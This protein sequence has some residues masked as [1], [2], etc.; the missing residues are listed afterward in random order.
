MAPTTSGKNLRKIGESLGRFADSRA[1]A[2][3]PRDR[4]V[5]QA[6]AGTVKVVAGASYGTI[7]A[8][9]HASEQQ[10]RAVISA[11]ELLECLKSLKTKSEYSFEDL[12]KGWEIGCS[13]GGTDFLRL[14]KKLPKFL[15]P[16]GPAEHSQGYIDIPGDTLELMGNMLTATGDDIYGSPIN[17][18]G[19]IY[20]GDKTVQ[21]NSTN[22]I[23]FSSVIL[24]GNYD[25]F[26]FF[27][28]TMLEAARAIGDARMEF[29]TN[30]LLTL[31]NESYRVVAPYSSLS[32]YG[33]LAFKPGARKPIDFRAVVD[34]TKFVKTLV[35]HAK[36]DKDGRVAVYYAD[37]ALTVAPFE[38]AK[39]GWYARA[40]NLLK[41][42][43]A[44]K[45]KQV[46]I[47]L[48]TGFGQP[49][50]VR[51]PE[52]TIEIAPVELTLLKQ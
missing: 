41:V 40:E 8:T 43:R 52:W 36:L 37:N 9:V 5:V 17:V 48:R 21:F 35:E 51:I 12:N 32:R 47:G 20:T 30:D 14:D 25:L 39:A 16:P 15:L 24:P 6:A 50:N 1:T 27:K 11:R 28:G 46:G 29:W 44:T 49:I 33:P 7:I 23:R 34:R 3:E 18:A 13:L 2:K 26:G 19:R 22:S 31:E 4:V 45:A 10:W 38:G 42:L